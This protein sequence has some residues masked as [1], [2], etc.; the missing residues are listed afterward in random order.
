MG[1][2]RL[3]DSTKMNAKNIEETLFVFIELQ[4]EKETEI[5]SQDQPDRRD[6][7]QDGNLLQRMNTWEL[8][9]W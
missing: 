2:H 5:A 1:K 4:P 6:A 7:M 9:D 3:H 8:N